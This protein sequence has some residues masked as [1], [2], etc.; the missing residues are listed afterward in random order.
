MLSNVCCLHHLQDFKYQIINKFSLID[1]ASH[2]QKKYN[3]LRGEIYL[4][5]ASECVWGRWKSVFEKHETGDL[6]N[7][8]TGMPFNQ[9]TH[10]KQMKPL[11]REFFIALQGLLETE[12]GKATFHILYMQ[13]TAKRCWV[14]P[15]I[16][17]TKPK[18]FVPSW[19][20]M[21]EWTENK[22]KKTTIVQEL[23]KL[24]PEKKLF[25]DGEVDEAH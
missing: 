17:F 11:V 1:N 3:E 6:I 7:P 21:K 2:K 22:K 4:I 24:V 14:H 19:Y 15:K 9:T 23:H 16:V 10:F 12:M 25:V 8:D 18:S 5:T 20:T 13:P